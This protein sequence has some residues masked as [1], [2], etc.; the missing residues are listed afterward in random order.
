MLKDSLVISILLYFASI[1]LLST[2]RVS[3]LRFTC[4]HIFSFSISDT[5][6][7]FKINLHWS[8]SRQFSRFCQDLYSPLPI[9]LRRIA[10][11]TT[12]DILLSFV[13]F[14]PLISRK[15]IDDLDCVLELRITNIRW[16]MTE[17]SKAI[18]II[19]LPSDIW[20]PSLFAFEVVI[21]PW[22]L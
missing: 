3:C 22:I 16:M 5:K 1:I 13:H 18:T 2:F 17:S 15:S 12:G 19:T 9:N 11:K 4:P 6:T 7:F 20:V 21:F 8:A 14:F 10:L